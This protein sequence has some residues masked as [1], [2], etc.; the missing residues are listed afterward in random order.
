MLNVTLGRHTLIVSTGR[1]TATKAYR[2]TTGGA[3]TMRAWM[4]IRRFSAILISNR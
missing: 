1:N 2:K 4:P 3:G